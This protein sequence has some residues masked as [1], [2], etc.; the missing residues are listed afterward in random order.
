MLERSSESPAI[1]ILTVAAGINQQRMAR[2]RV[3]QLRCCIGNGAQEEQLGIQRTKNAKGKIKDKHAI[4][5]SF[6]GKLKINELL[7][8]SNHPH[9]PATPSAFWGA[10]FR[11]LIVH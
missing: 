10:S 2:R 9:F 5:D 7:I 11:A 6:R 3:V 8:A 1:H 4:R